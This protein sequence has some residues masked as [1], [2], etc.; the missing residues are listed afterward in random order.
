ML[1][2][3]ARSFYFPTS[4]ALGLQFLS[5]ITTLVTFCFFK[6]SHPNGYGVRAHGGFDLHFIIIHDVDHLSMSLSAIC[7]S[8]L[9]KLLFEPFACFETWFGGFVVEL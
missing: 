1:S 7:I 5:V 9:E 6:N 2:T 3:V 4:N 8:S